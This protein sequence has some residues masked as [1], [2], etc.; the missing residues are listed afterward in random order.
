M[1]LGL[2]MADCE[3]ELSL[4]IQQQI[5]DGADIR[6]VQGIFDSIAQLLKLDGAELAG[7]GLERVCGALTC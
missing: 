4:G 2:K 5:A 3:V 1:Q 7:A 6:S